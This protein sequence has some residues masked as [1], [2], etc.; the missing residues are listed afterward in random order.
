MSAAI[1]LYSS[2]AGRLW[3]ALPA[4]PHSRDNEK[5][6]AAAEVVLRVHG[7][8]IGALRESH[9]VARRDMIGHEEALRHG[10]LDDLLRGDADVSTMVEHAEPF[11]LD[12]SKAHHV[13][14]AAPRARTGRSTARRRCWNDSSST[15]PAIATSWSTPRTAGWSC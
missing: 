6:R 15:G 9:Q 7:A 11:G 8:A 4:V 10:F 3:R 5:V 1:E 14:V 12:L 2:A 13:A